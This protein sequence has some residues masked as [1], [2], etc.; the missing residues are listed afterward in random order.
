MFMFIIRLYLICRPSRGNVI[1]TASNGW[2]WNGRAPTSHF[3]CIFHLFNLLHAVGIWSTSYDFL[4]SCYF[5]RLILMSFLLIRLV[6][7]LN[8]LLIF[9]FL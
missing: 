6:V 2:S 7:L 3:H 5:D 1:Y 4:I 8:V 9:Y